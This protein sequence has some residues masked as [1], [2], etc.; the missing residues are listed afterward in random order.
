[1]IPRSLFMKNMGLT[2]YKQVYDIKSEVPRTTILCN[3]G[4]WKPDSY[5]FYTEVVNESQPL[6]VTR[7]KIKELYM[8]FNFDTGTDKE[9]FNH[10]KRSRKFSIGHEYG[11]KYNQASKLYDLRLDNDEEYTFDEWVLLK[12]VI[13]KLQGKSW[14][15]L[16][17][18]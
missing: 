11:L 5:D 2:G 12:N 10:Y 1:M 4:I 18:W 6:E 7:K 8:R 13:N 17:F 16:I 3:T 15:N 14:G 9:L